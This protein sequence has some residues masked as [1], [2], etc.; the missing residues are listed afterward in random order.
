MRSMTGFGAGSS[1]L[2][3]GR[4]RLEIRAL[5]H[6]HTD[7]RLRLP[8]ELSEQGSFFEQLIRSRLGRGRFDVSVRVEGDIGARVEIDEAKLRAVYTSL[9]ALGA[10]LSPGTEIS[11]ATLATLPQVLTT[12]GPAEQEM[13]EALKLA[14]ETAS[15]ELS[16]MCHAEG[17]AL[18]RDLSTRL[19]RLR[20]LTSELRS[21]ASDLVSR[22]RT[23]LRERI[24]QLLGGTAAQL[25][26]ERLEQEIALLADKSDITEELVRLESHFEQFESLLGQS[27]S[28]G[29]RLDFL[30]QEISREVNTAG[31]KSQHAEVAHIVVQM[32]SEVE[33]LREQVQNID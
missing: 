3:S 22:H 19:T 2:G 20:D 28:V 29:R 16:K 9:K 7:V 10:E 14:F 31:S 17:A 32:K 6:K 18:L 21:G 11:L 23:R 26:S 8:P 33:R 13:Q 5:N 4:L 30:L 24:N 12:H 27:E 25:A 15:E 1:A